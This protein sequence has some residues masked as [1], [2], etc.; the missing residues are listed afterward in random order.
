LILPGL[1]KESV[2][3]YLILVIFALVGGVMAVLAFENF[4]ALSVEV[5]LVLL[6]WHVPAAPLGVLLLL[7]CV[8]GALL[9]YVVTLL[10]AVRERREL[11]R[12]RKRVAELEAIQTGQPG[13]LQ[14]QPLPPQFYMPMPGTQAYRVQYLFPPP[15]QPE[16]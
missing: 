1:E 5:H 13:A 6:G 2:V 4:S 14:Q 3:L 15:Q 8:L 10:S 9:I 12:L 7:S 16:R 11:R